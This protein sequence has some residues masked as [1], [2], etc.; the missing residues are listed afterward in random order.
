MFRAISLLFSGL[1]LAACGSSSDTGEAAFA[2]VKE[3][4][5]LVDV[6]T[7][8]EFAGGHLP[9]A[10]NIPHGD[11]VA[12]IKALGADK[13]AD[14]VLY[15]RSGN[16]SGIAAGSLAGA[17]YTGAVNAGAFSALKPAWDAG[18]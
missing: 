16:R 13:A 11:I 1:F 12:G 6:R 8:Q 17:G 14:I 5:L 18:G 3:G 15:C 9:G 7:A 2:A 10:I 4:A